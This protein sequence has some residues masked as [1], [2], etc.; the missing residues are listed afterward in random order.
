MSDS[1][2]KRNYWATNIGRVVGT[3]LFL[4]GLFWLSWG[5]RD[6][7]FAMAA[8]GWIG[9][10][11]WGLFSL[12]VGEHLRRLLLHGPRTGEKHFFA[13][14]LGLVQL[15]LLPSPQTALLTTLLFGF[16]LFTLAGA[17]AGALQDL[18]AGEK[19]HLAASLCYAVALGF[20]PVPIMIDLLSQGEEW[21]GW[22]LLSYTPLLVARWLL[23][24]RARG[25]LPA[26]KVLSGEALGW[27]LSLAVLSACTLAPAMVLSVWGKTY[28]V[29]QL[30]WAGFFVWRLFE[31]DYLWLERAAFGVS[32]LFGAFVF[33]TLPDGGPL[34][35]SLCL[36]TG[37]FF[38]LFPCQGIRVIAAHDQAEGME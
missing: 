15:F 7:S 20:L 8:V 21:S 18:G 28:L 37:L 34:L 14:A 10:F 22:T 25:T 4:G 33:A 38:G 32:F 27:I 12:L 17:V 6:R 1:F 13:L 2:E 35:G 31:P 5:A 3:G 9:L 11:L 26:R 16:G 29:L 30:L 36:T 24:E 23:P 19:G